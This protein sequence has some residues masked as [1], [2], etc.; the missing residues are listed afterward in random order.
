MRT[1]FESPSPLLVVV[2]ALVVA[3]SAAAVVAA[4]ALTR[5]Q[6]PEPVASGVT[7]AC[8]MHPQVTSP[9]PG[10]C[11]ICRMALEP[12]A[13]KAGAHEPASLTL[14]RNKTL[15]GFDSV[16]RV[17]K[18]ESAFDMRAWA[19]AESGDVGVALYPR[20]WAQLLKPGDEGL[21]EPQSGPRVAN[22]H[23]IKVRCAEQ[24]PEPWDAATVLV[25]FRGDGHAGA[26]LQESEIG[27]V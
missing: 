9:R 4:F 2:R 16:S 5:R 1:H 25:R 19:W 14:P 20:D 12:K 8:P 13:P 6:A 23:G 27:S 7:Y 15:A 24:A 18:F 11:P 26:A 22:P 17:K 21:F 3:L 10:D